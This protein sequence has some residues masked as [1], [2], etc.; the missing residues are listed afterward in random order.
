MQ[1]LWLS[2]S[3]WKM[4]SLD[5][6]LYEMQLEVAV[7]SGAYFSVLTAVFEINWPGLFG[8]KAL[9]SRGLKCQTKCKTKNVFM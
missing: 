2:H 7:D 5:A 3:K 8:L 9:G 4:S 6:Q 1:A